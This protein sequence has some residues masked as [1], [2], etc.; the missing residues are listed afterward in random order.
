MRVADA[1]H[2]DHRLLVEAQK[3]VHGLLELMNCTERS[4][5]EL[6]QQQQALRELEQLVEGLSGLAGA[7]ALLRH[8]PV[9]MPAAT[10]A[11]KDRAL[12]LLSDTLL[13]TSVKRRTATI[14]KPVP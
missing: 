7:R 5:L 6:E 9:A 8:E 3:E 13:I 11:L 1:S 12:F 10:G 2:P 4:S 14:K